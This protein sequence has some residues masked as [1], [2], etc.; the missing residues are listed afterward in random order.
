MWYVSAVVSLVDLIPLLV[1]SSSHFFLWKLLPSHFLHGNPA[2]FGIFKTE[3]EADRSWRQFSNFQIISAKRRSRAADK[4]LPCHRLDQKYLSYKKLLAL[5]RLISDR[6]C[7]NM[8]ADSSETVAAALFS[9]EASFVPVVRG[10]PRALLL[11]IL[12]HYFP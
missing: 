11:A 4:Y 10:S 5:K 3:L 8:L 2:L 12:F 7:K 9:T 1:T 6:I